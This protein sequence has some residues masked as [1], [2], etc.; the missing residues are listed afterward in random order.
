MHNNYCIIWSQILSGN[1][2]MPG[3]RLVKPYMVFLYPVKSMCYQFMLFIS[4]TNSKANQGEKNRFI[5]KGQIKMLCW[6]VYAQMSSLP[7]PQLFPT[8]QRNRMP[9]IT[10]H[11]S[12]GL[13]NQKSLQYN[14]AKGQIT[15]ILLPTQCTDQWK[16]GTRSTRCSEFRS[17]IPQILTDVELKPNSY[18]QFASF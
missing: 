1:S 15:S 12:L 7:C 4:N 17:D 2:N 18:L 6:V 3:N 11:P 14:L 13:T 9:F 16:R 5:Q 10:P 8:E